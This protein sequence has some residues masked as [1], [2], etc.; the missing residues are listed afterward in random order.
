MIYL[1][2]SKI[3]TW[4]IDNLIRIN[5]WLIAKSMPKGGGYFMLLPKDLQR[6]FKEAQEQLDAE[7][8]KMVN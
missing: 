8:R 6:Q 4:W 3:L 7:D 5:W 1:W 2:L